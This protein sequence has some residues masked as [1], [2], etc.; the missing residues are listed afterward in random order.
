M[1]MNIKLRKPKIGFLLFGSERFKELGVGTASGT[2]NER[3]QRESVRITNKFV[4]DLDVINPGVLYDITEVRKAIQ[5][6]ESEQVDCILV[7]FLSWAEDNLWIRFL[8]DSNID[9]PL[10]YYCLTKDHIPF[11]SCDDEND[12]IEFLS[13]GGLVGMLVGSG[14]IVRHKR[15]AKVVVGTLDEKSDVIVEY[16]KTCMIH[17]I[18]KQSK[19]GVMPAYNEIMWSTYVDPYEYFKI[20]PSVHFISYDE[21]D[22]CSNSIPD[23]TVLEYK[24]QLIAKYPVASSVEDE[25]FIA[26]LR[27]SLGLVEVV[28]KYD[29]DILT[30]N[31]VDMRLFEKIGLRP[32]FYPNEINQRLAVLCPE[33]DLGAALATFILKMLSRNQ[34][35]FIEPFYVDASRQ[36]FSGGH[37]GPN[38]YNYE[39]SQELVEISVDSR[40]AKTS[41]KYAGAPF[42]WLRIPPGIM[43]MV[44]ISQGDGGVKLIAS[45]VESIEGPHF[46]N[47]YAHSE[48]KPLN[49]SV[50]EFF[51]TLLTHGTTQHFAVT[52][53]NYVSQLED[54]AHLFEFDF[55]QV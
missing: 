52:P 44:H 9:T 7:M 23:G 16:A 12:F 30:I 40:F 38:D 1:R 29:L 20:G 50:N 13:S 14:S 10:I 53:G 25:K 33:A 31:D 32:G 35:N 8:R 54:L 15:W 43:T 19:V 24:E 37:A 47:S 27:Y 42:A 48:F 22:Q 3:V 4:Q 11:Q 6:Y 28:R 18:V 26:S 39:Q 21:L 55:Y 45:L 5:V 51:Q 41:Y 49:N 46:I 17:S 2:Y 36:I 34:V